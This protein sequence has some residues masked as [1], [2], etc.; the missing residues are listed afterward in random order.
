M[1]FSFLLVGGA[2][3]LAKGFMC[4]SEQAYENG[5]SILGI[6]PLE[7]YCDNGQYVGIMLAVVGF[8]LFVGMLYLLWRLGIEGNAPE[9]EPEHKYRHAH[10]HI[11]SGFKNLDEYHHVHVIRTGRSFVHPWI[12]IV[13][14][15]AFIQEWTKFGPLSWLLL[16]GSI[17]LFEIIGWWILPK[18]NGDDGPNLDGFTKNDGGGEQGM[19]KGIEVPFAE[20]TD[21]TSNE[22]N[23]KPEIS[24]NQTS[25]LEER[26][27]NLGKQLVGINDR[28][29][30]FGDQVTK[31]E[32]EIASLRQQ[33]EELHNK[34]ASSAQI[35][36]IKEQL[37]ELAIQLNDIKDKM[38][39]INAGIAPIISYPYTK[40]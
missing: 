31:L 3:Y 12:L 15:Y 37:N 38:G 26:I 18:P 7:V 32:E 40:T 22:L 9:T 34:Q 4:W 25:K 17:I 30:V 35:S 23:K 16:F 27:D 8:I 6:L 33:V 13:A 10:K 1:L 24:S 20:S 11:R 29:T 21:A 14:V 28:Q 19:L 2:W 5:S 39:N 36:E